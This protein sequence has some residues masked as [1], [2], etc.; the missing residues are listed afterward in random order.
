M[1]EIMK[2]KLLLSI[3]KRRRRENKFILIWVSKVCLIQKCCFYLLRSNSSSCSLLDTMSMYL[4][5]NT[6]EGLTRRVGLHCCG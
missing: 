4:H 1:L 5:K 3:T 2:I 6:K